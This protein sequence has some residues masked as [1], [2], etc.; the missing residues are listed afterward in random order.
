MNQQEAHQIELEQQERDTEEAL[1]RLYAGRGSFEDL[2]ILAQSTGLRATAEQI[3]QA[4]HQMGG[5]V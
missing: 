1:I 2:K 5:L 3:S 4:A